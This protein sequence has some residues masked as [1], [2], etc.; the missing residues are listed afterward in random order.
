MPLAEGE[1]RLSYSANGIHPGASFTF[2]TWKSGYYLL[3]PFEIKN[4]DGETHDTPLPREDGVRLGQDFTAGA[5]ITFEI[6]VD[7]VDAGSTPLA[8]HGANLAAVS[9]MEQ[10]WDAR[11]VRSRMATPAVLSTTQGGRSRC[12]YG[13]PRQFAPA[14]SKLTRQGY[15]PVVA[16]FSAIHTGSF[17]DV[18]QNVRVDMAPP[19]HRGLKG[20]L[21]APLA[22]VGPGSIRTPGEIV[23]G[24][25]RPTWPVITI[26]G[27]IS[28]PVC[29]LVGRWKLQLNLALRQGEKVTI[30][31]RPWA[32]TVLKGS[33]SVAGLITR[34][35]P[36]LENLLLPPGR[37]DVVLRGTDATATAFMTVAWRDAY[38]YM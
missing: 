3:E 4:A 14:A 13:R 15:T 23:V 24:G 34:S 5:T 29:E 26:T 32:R 18:E 27:P 7:T 17:D 16:S 25:D 31:P 22:M 38:A 36:L 20:P 8:R 10:A 37:Q 28:Q 11:A 21:K 33:A 2:G 30:D 35:S 19:P 9:R 1:W 6:G 12:W